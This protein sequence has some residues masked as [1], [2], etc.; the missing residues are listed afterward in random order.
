VPSPVVLVHVTQRRI[1]PSLCCYSVTSGWEEFRYARS[2]ETCLGKTESSSQT[3]SAGADNDSIIFVVLEM[4]GLGHWQNP[5]SLHT[6]NNWI[7]IADEW[8]C[9]LC[10]QRRVCYYPRYG[11]VSCCS[12]QKSH[13]FRD[14]PAGRVEEKVLAWLFN[15]LETCTQW[16]RHHAM[17]K[18]H[19]GNA[20]IILTE[21]PA[22]NLRM[23]IE[24]IVKEGNTRARGEMCRRCSIYSDVW[25]RFRDLVDV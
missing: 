6:Y 5:E 18:T 7:F 1:D 9:L 10:S 13:Y 14:I 11:S 15:A 2:V 16:I 8:I 25:R 24:D 17:R 19:R 23:A 3:C 20:Y 4:L 21:G 12:S 22:V